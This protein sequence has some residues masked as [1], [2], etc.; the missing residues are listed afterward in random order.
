METIIIDPHKTSH[1]LLY[2]HKLFRWWTFAYYTGENYV[3]TEYT[4]ARR[5]VGIRLNADTH[6][7]GST[8]G[9]RVN[10]Q[11]INLQPINTT[12]TTN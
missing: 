7:F 9:K 5:N 10:V 3:A 12:A 8:I 4:N 2:L 6:N 1:L 11:Q